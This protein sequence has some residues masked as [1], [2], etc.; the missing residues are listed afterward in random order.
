MEI[1]GFF[2][3]LCHVIFSGNY[4]MERYFAEAYAW[5]DVLL[6]TDMWCFSGSYLE[7]VHMIIC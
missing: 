4:L 2:R 5:E 7:N 3:Q 6:S 1:S